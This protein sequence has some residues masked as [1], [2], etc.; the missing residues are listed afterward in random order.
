MPPARAESPGAPH[1]VLPS[2][3]PGERS[4]LAAAPDLT[5]Q[6]LYRVTRTGEGPM[7]SALTLSPTQRN[8][9]LHHYRRHPDPAVR[10]R[11]HIILMLA[12]GQ[13][14]TTVAA[15]LFTS[16]STIAR[17]QQRFEDEGVEGLLSHPC[18]APPR[19][20]DEVETILRQA[21][22]HSPDEWGYRAVSWTVLLL[23]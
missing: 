18:G 2:R 21:L 23:R 16:P 10:L 14:W 19:W 11:A 8:A 13:P 12:E 15:V 3:P 1:D 5:A 9:L 6:R 7:S 17:W 4:S 20:S 22:E